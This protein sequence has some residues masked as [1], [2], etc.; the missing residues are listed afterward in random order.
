MIYVEERMRN[1]EV[2]IPG[3]FRYSPRPEE[4]QL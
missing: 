1:I 2:E 4:V 3:R